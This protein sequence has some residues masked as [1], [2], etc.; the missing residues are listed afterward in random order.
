MSKPYGAPQYDLCC[1]LA[2]FELMTDSP[3]YRAA[4]QRLTIRLPRF[5]FCRT[6]AQIAIDKGK[7]KAAFK[8]FN[9]SVGRLVKNARARKTRQVRNV[10]KGIASKRR[11]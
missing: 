10:A 9:A 6:P 3:T 7:I 5:R 1:M 2:H 11:K 8:E 4:Y